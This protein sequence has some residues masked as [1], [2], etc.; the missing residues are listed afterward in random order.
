MRPRLETGFELKTTST[1]AGLLA[2][3]VLLACSPAGEVSRPAAAKHPLP[4]W[5]DGDAR[6]DILEFIARVTDRASRAGGGFE[7]QERV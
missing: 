6:Q 3:T 2:L 1:I 5:N 4:S 7:H